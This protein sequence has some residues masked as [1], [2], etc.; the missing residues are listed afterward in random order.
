[1]ALHEHYALLF[2]PR[3]S[4]S[5]RFM[6]INRSHWIKRIST[7]VSN[8]TTK[9]TVVK[10]CNFF[11]SSAVW[12]WNYSNHFSFGRPTSRILCT[13]NHFRRTL[14]FY[15]SW[16]MSKTEIAFRC[17]IYPSGSSLGRMPYR[18]INFHSSSQW[19]CSVK[20]PKSPKNK[21]AYMIRRLS[22]GNN[23]PTVWLAFGQML[24]QQ[25]WCFAMSSSCFFAM[26][27]T[28][29]HLLRQWRVIVSTNN[30][31]IYNRS[32]MIV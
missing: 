9:L 18:D 6:F 25:V 4:S 31:N 30:N 16:S 13:T 5:Y 26:M 12:W 7:F 27:T 20:R 23:T 2:L 15:L 8:F 21:I 1:M 14:V 11:N 24:H 32:Y 28:R 29:R 19:W 22:T 10:N 3:N 17:S